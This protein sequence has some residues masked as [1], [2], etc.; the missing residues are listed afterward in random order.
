[1]AKLGIHK[2][3][4]VEVISGS[5]KGKKGVVLSVQPRN[6]KIRVQGV[7]MATHFDRQEGIHQ[8]E[9]L[10]DYSNVKLVSKGKKE[11]KSRTKSK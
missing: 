4:S 10:L 6:M 9:A 5:E 11:K 7:K 3:D 1:M 2:G 8:K